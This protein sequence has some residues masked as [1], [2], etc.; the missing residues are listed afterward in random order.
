MTAILVNLLITLVVLGVIY[1]LVSFI[2][3]PA[4]FPQIVQGL[5]I[6]LAIVV[7]LSAFGVIPGGGLH[8]RL[9]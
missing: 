2:P 1:W 6:I 8:F 3:L 9:V 4:P 5:F 7:I